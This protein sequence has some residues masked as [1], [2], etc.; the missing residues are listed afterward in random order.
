MPS[1]AK[2][3]ARKGSRV[4]V[5]AA[6]LTLSALLCVA[7]LLR[8]SHGVRVSQEAS[9][10]TPAPQAPTAA[11]ERSPRAARRTNPVADPDAFWHPLGM[12]PLDVDAL[13]RQ[14]AARPPLPRYE[15]K[16]RP[17]VSPTMECA[18]SAEPTRLS[19]A[20]RAELAPEPDADFRMPHEETW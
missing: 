9:L 18:S 4:V 7:S 14:R 8:D 11:R 15:P 6:V 20:A 16:E 13:A 10:R 12:R 19:P 3:S 17:V 5:P 1:K 2:Q